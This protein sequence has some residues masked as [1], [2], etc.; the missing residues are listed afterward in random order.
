MEMRRTEMRTVLRQTPIYEMGYSGPAGYITNYDVVPVQVVERCHYCNRPK[1]TDRNT[2]LGC[3]A[4][5]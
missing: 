4:E 3:G 1:E 2:C 5:Y